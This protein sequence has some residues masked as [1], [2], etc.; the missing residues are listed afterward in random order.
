MKIASFI[1]LVGMAATA[2][3]FFQSAAPAMKKSNFAQ[4]AVD[5]YGQ[6]YPFGQAPKEKSILSKYAKFGVP[7]VDIDGTRYDKVGK[8]TG[9]RMTDITEKQAADT[10]NQLASVYGGE[11]ALEM[12]KI[13]P[14]CL[15]FNKEQFKGSFDAWTDVFGEEETKEMYVNEFVRHSRND[16]DDAT[17]HMP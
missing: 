4:E 5:V 12:V 3:A 8:G 10:F 15:T 14:V 1:L 9:K 13:F 11:R 2:N 17:C 7:E 6:Q 16:K